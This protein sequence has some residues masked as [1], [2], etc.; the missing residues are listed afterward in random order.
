MRELDE[1]IERL[2][3]Q[4]HGGF[5]RDQASA[6]GASPSGC[7]RRLRSGAWVRSAEAGVYLLR[8][9]PNTWRQRLMACVL[10][11]PPGTLASHRA[12]AVLYGV[13]DRATHGFEEDRLRQNALVLAGWTLLRFTWADVTE[14]GLATVAAVARGLRAA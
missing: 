2:A 3:R 14:R 13:R 10:A 4:Q 6:A 8:G 9:Q 1:A 7:D 5:T 12:A 11:G